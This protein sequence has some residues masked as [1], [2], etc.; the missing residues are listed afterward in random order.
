M[1]IPHR[2]V[3]RKDLETKRLDGLRTAKTDRLHNHHLVP[4]VA[5]A[6][7]PSLRGFSELGGPSQ[8]RC[9]V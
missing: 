6:R 9:K 8:R 7:N 5:L 4:E 3:T 1:I 2:E